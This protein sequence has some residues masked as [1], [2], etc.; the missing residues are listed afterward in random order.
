MRV[1][2]A[3]FSVVGVGVSAVQK[4]NGGNGKTQRVRVRESVSVH[5]CRDKW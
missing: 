3:K 4:S 5:F 2:K 1:S